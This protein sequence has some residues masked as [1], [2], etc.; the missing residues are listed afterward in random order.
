MVGQHVN[1]R[2]QGLILAQRRRMHP[3]TFRVKQS[4]MCEFNPRDGLG[5]GLV[6]QVYQ[7]VRERGRQLCLTLSFLG[8]EAQLQHTTLIPIATPLQLFQYAAC[9]TETAHD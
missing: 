6:K 7:C 3:A 4:A 5:L 8:I 2:V 1:I 9:V